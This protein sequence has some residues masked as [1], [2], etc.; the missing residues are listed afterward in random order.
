MLACGSTVS[1]TLPPRR[2]DY[3]TGTA[4]RG[5]S[6]PSTSRTPT[7]I[8]S[9]FSGSP[10]A[11]ATPNG[12]GPPT[13]FFSASITPPSWSRT[14][15]RV[16]GSIETAS[17]SRWPANPRTTVPSRS[18]STMCRGARLRITTLRAA[19]GPGIELLEYLAPRDGRPVPADLRAND[20]AHWQ[21]RLITA[22]ATEASAALAR[23]GS[24]LVSPGGVDTSR[25]EL[26]FRRAVG[27]DDPDGHVMQLVEP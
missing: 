24:R 16:Y 22:D 11:R 9:R 20:L 4:R 23:S 13:V 3:P 8:S 27:V 1:A 19:R 18:G 21:T 10:P 26:G 25:A 5:A 15:T 2:S 6:A 7:G 12:T 17:G 14:L